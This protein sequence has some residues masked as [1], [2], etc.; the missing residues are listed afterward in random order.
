VTIYFPTKRHSD[1]D[2]FRKLSMDALSGIVWEDDRQISMRQSC[3]RRSIGDNPRIE[4]LSMCW[5]EQWVRLL[6]GQQS[7]LYNFILIP[8]ATFARGALVTSSA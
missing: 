2:N 7:H 3:V 4:S 8:K 6:L 1:W 5:D